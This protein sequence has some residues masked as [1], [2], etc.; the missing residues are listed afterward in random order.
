MKTP[1]LF[2][3]LLVCSVCF[4]TAQVQENSRWAVVTEDA[5]R[6]RAEGSLQAA[7]LGSLNTGD[8]VEILG[9]S[10]E[11][12]PV[13]KMLDYWYHIQTNDGVEGWCYGYYLR[14]LR[15]IEYRGIRMSYDES[16]SKTIEARTRQA[17][18]LFN[19]F[20]W[21]ESVTFTLEGYLLDSPEQHQRSMQFFP[22]KGSKAREDFEK[23]EIQKLLDLLAGG[24]PGRRIPTIPYRH[25]N[26]IFK[27]HYKII[28]FKNGSG[29]RVITWWGNDFFWPVPTTIDYQFQGIT[30]D[31]AYSV[32]ALFEVKRPK[33]ETDSITSISSQEFG[34]YFSI[35]EKELNAQPPS[36]FI[37]DLSLLDGMIGS[38]N[39]TP[40]WGASEEKSILVDPTSF[41]DVEQVLFP[42]DFLLVEAGTFQMGSTGGSDDEKPV[43]RVTISSSFYMSPYEVTQEQWR[44][45]MESKP[46]KFEGDDLPVVRIRWY[47]AV[48]YCNRL[49]R[50]NGLTPC[51]SGIGNN[52]LCDFSANGYRLPTEAEWEYAARGGNK[53]REHLYS[54]SN[55]EDDIGWYKDNSGSKNFTGIHPVGQKMPNE[56]GLFDLSGNAWEFCWDWFGNYSPA[57]QIDPMGPQNSDR[58]VMRGGAWYTNKDQMRVANRASA[59]ILSR[60]GFRPVRTA[61]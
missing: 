51:Y 34:K 44:E 15:E 24:K 30:E 2:S 39:M 22:L 58:R 12:F 55:L 56:L 43:H 42:D 6:I 52:I 31:G 38:L 45:V 25:A 49:S 57:S 17:D 27:S 3:T 60:G 23:A 29:Y 37:P 4:I 18:S 36:S 19:P 14:I 47:E 41:K 7:I 50:K 20:G 21:P 13:G 5:L 40:D 11:K 48:E 33:V 54:G 53:S 35:F 1:I 9:Q 10:E 59:N 8:R 16:L 26:V 61:E 46:F 32:S 28:N